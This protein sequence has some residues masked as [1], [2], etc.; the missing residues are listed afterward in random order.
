LIVFALSNFSLAF[1]T[2][3]TA[4][5][6]IKPN[7]VGIEQTVLICLRVEPSP[8]TAG[9]TSG[10]WEGITVV[11]TRPDGSTETIGPFT[12]D[13]TGATSFYYTPDRVGHWTFQ[14]SF[15]GYSSSGETYDPSQS[16]EEGLDVQ[17]DPVD[18]ELEELTCDALEDEDPCL[19]W[20]ILVG[21]LIL[22]IL[23]LLWL[24]SRRG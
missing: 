10:G 21:I 8:T 22:I 9:I 15:P 6:Q 4:S 11:A 19:I 20:K 23:I 2:A 12:T 16:P 3:T 24:L 17:P 1:A 5:V 13:S 18:Y 14:M 7:P